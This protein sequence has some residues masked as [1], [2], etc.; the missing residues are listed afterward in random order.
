MGHEWGPNEER[1]V[2]RSIDGGTIWKRV[3]FGAPTKAQSEWVEINGRQFTTVMG[4][5]D[6]ILKTDLPQFNDHLKTA[7]VSSTISL[8]AT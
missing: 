7:G 1:G 8:A 5:L 2:F 6:Q 4:Q 3:L